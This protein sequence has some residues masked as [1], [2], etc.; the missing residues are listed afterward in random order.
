MLPPGTR[1]GRTSG[2]S[3]KGMCI[4]HV[5]RKYKSFGDDIANALA[6]NCISVYHTLSFSYN[7]VVAEINI[8]YPHR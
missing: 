7:S 4:R 5:L 3:L 8:V 6:N 2:A 1:S